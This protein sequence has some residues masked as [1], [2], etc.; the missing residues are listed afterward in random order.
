MT[1]DPWTNQNSQTMNQ[2]PKGTQNAEDPWANQSQTMNQSPMGMRNG[3]DPWIDPGVN[4]FPFSGDLTKNQSPTGK[5]ITSDP[6]MN[7][8]VFQPSHT[9]S[10]TKDPWINSGLF[11]NNKLPPKMP[12]A[13]KDHWI[14]SGNS[15]QSPSSGTQNRPTADPW[16]NPGV[17]G[18]MVDE[19]PYAPMA[20]SNKNYMVNRLPNVE[21]PYA[22]PMNN[23]MN[24]M[25]MD[26]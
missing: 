7:Q 11:N 22:P 13:P 21:I 6:W 26:K 8:G 10:P 4:K 17:N 24:S 3:A 9:L 5:L 20:T 25:N 2:S 23:N 1:K 19:I 12:N 18:Q 14:I 16:V 15:K